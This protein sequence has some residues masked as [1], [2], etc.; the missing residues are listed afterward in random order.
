MLQQVTRKK[1]PRTPWTDEEVGTLHRMVLH[2]LTRKEISDSMNRSYDSVKSKIDQEGITKPHRRTPKDCTTMPIRVSQR[3]H[4]RYKT[5][6]RTHASNF[7]ET[8]EVIMDAFMNQVYE[9]ERVN[10]HRR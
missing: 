6:C 7:G 5:F 4:D 2:G 3:F 10:K 9:D 1:L 8:I